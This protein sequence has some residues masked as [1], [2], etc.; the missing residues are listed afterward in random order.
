MVKG[1]KW[2]REM[3]KLHYKL[4]KMK[5]TTITENKCLI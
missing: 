3:I 4:K 2:K 5:L 1:K